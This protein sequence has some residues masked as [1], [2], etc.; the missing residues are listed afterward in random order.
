[1]ANYNPKPYLKKHQIKPEG[2]EPLSKRQLQV[3][4]PEDVKIR[5]DEIPSKQRTQLVRQWI[6]EGLSRYLEEY[7]EYSDK[8]DLNEVMAG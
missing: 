7:Q 8:G 6:A 5:L 4:L 2:A 3:R 1:M